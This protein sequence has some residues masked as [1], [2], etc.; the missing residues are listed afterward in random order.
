MGRAA[1]RYMTLETI[2][3]MGDNLLIKLLSVAA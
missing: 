1:R 2:V 3:P